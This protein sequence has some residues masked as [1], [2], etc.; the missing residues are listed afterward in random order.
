MQM[1]RSSRVALSL[2]FGLTIAAAGRTLRAQPTT[3]GLLSSEEVQAL[4][5]N[6]NVTGPSVSENQEGG[7]V[8]CRYMWG[9]GNQ[10]FTLALSVQPASRMFVG[11]SADAIRQYMKAATPETGDE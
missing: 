7:G 1:M 6:Q 11:M 4:A 5:P 10:H 3:C 2:V 8:T 9:A